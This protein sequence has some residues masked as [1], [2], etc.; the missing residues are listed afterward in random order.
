MQISV[1]G[2]HIQITQS[3]EAY[4]HKKLS[5][6]ERHFQ[7]ILSSQVILTVDKNAKKQRAASI[8]LALKFLQKP[9]QIISTPQ[10][11]R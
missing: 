2:H 11:I 7:P 4:I 6:L 1:S 5:R 3:I 10:L 9:N 8:F